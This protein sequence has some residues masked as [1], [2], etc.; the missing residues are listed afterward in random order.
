MPIAN[1]CSE[2]FSIWAESPEDNQTLLTTAADGLSSARQVSGDAACLNA[3]PGSLDVVRDA[4]GGRTLE[5][6]GEMPSG[7]LHVDF[8]RQAIAYWWAEDTPAIEERVAAAW[9]GWGA[10]WLRESYETQLEMANVDVRFSNPTLIE[11]QRDRVSFLRKQCHREARNL[12]RE[13]AQKVGA[14]S[15]N[16]ATDETRGSVGDEA[17]KLRILD[18]LSKSLD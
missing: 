10:T 14:T 8:D 12:A 16:P 3:G 13:L 4:P 11:L 5:W 18:E 1:C 17:Q 7:G 2:G 6:S 9:P 15:I